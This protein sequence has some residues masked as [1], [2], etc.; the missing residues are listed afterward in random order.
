MPRG[1]GTGPAGLGPLTGRRAGFCAGY[2]VPG[3]VNPITNLGFG[4]GFGRGRGFG[5]RFAYAQPYPYRP[6]QIKKEDE[7]RML[8]KEQKAIKQE[9]ED[10]NKRL[11]ELKKK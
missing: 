2:D 11:Q 9:L 4:R 1:D 3:F 7:I 5:F 10:I 8:E 6:A